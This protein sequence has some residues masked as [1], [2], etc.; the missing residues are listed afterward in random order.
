MPS[1]TS[2]RVWRKMIQ[3]PGTTLASTEGS[4]PVTRQVGEVTATCPGRGPSGPRL[5]FMPPSPY[6]LEKN[7]SFGGY[8]NFLVLI[9]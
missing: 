9:Q 5:F 7:H 8:A 3:I 1:I 6:G 2:Y 4:P